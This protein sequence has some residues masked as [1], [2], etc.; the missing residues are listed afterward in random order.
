MSRYTT[1]PWHVSETL[2]S[3]AYR[4]YW[5]RPPVQPFSRLFSVW[6]HHDQNSLLL[7][8][9]TYVHVRRG[10]SC[11]GGR[12]TSL[13]WLC[14]NTK[15]SFCSRSDF[16][17]LDCLHKSCASYSGL[18]AWG[19]TQT[20]LNPTVL[21]SSHRPQNCRQSTNMLGESISP[22]P[23]AMRTAG[24]RAQL[25]LLNMQVRGGGGTPQT[26]TAGNSRGNSQKNRK[27]QPQPEV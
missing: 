11:S 14:D 9:P 6:K 26:R 3:Q 7:G 19:T 27:P 20:Y 12:H 1:S 22:C 4:A 16:D 21:Y 24:P 17:N 23:V 5:S 13:P 2:R 10:Q 18:Q 15:R 8:L 25:P